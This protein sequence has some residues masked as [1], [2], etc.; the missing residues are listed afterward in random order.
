MK[1]ATAIVVI[2]SL[3]LSLCGC[4]AAEQHGKDASVA[5][6]SVAPGTQMPTED[7]MAED[8]EALAAIGEVA[9][10]NGILTVSVTLPASLVGEGADQTKLDAEAGSRY[11]SARVNEDGSVTYKMTK[12]QH[13]EMLTSLKESIDGA[14]QEMI[15]SEEF[16]YGQIKYN[17]NMSVF[18]ATMTVSELGLADSFA[19]VAFYMYGGIYQI[20]CGDKSDSI[21]VNFYGPDGA[22]ITNA[23]SADM[24]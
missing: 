20:F 13:Q 24:Q 1:K 16:H 23:D 14:I 9:V 7:P 4:G 19:I 15:D 8:M 6:E 10:E 22:L 21:Q 3:V 12:A 2:L 18:D 11:Q 17:S 5:T